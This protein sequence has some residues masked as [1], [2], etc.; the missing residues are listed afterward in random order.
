MDID[1]R[2]CWDYIKDNEFLV[3]LERP[4][5]KKDVTYN[6]KKVKLEFIDTCYSIK[7]PLMIMYRGYT[8]NFQMNIFIYFLK[9]FTFILLFKLPFSLFIP[10]FSNDQYDDLM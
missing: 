8:Y 2:M 4:I 7:C 1:K 9:Q 5:S 6:T 3:D 10:K